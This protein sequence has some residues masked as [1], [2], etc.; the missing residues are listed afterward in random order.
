MYLLFA[1]VLLLLTVT[2]ITYPLFFSK[3]QDY[4]LTQKTVGKDF[5]EADVLLSSLSD[6]EDDYALG[7]VDKKEYQTQKIKLQRSYLEVKEAS[8]SS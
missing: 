3:I 6:L 7:R 2:A 5:S 4:F 1:I 8:T